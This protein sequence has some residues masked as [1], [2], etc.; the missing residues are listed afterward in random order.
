MLLR[1]ES[2]VNEIAAPFAISLPAISKHLQ[3]LEEAGLVARGRDAQRRPAR[4]TATPLASA[5]DWIDSYREF[6]DRSFDALDDHLAQQ[7]NQPHK[8]TH[9]QKGKTHD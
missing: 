5:A 4:L 7:H 6:W 3:V 9:N 2:T 8:G 1:G